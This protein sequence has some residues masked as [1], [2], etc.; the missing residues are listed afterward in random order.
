M[1]IETVFK[2]TSDAPWSL[3]GWTVNYKRL[4]ETTYAWY[5]TDPSG[6][7]HKYDG[8]WH[9]FYT[10]FNV[11]SIEHLLQSISRHTCTKEAIHKYI[12]NNERTETLSL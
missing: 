10:Q 6:H 2:D 1:P 7:N 5:L 11:K 12:L 9:G 4:D 3:K 8:M